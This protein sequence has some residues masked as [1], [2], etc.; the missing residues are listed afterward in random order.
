DIIR[1][2]YARMDAGRANVFDLFAD[3]FEFYFPKFG[4]GKGRAELEACTSRLGT[5]VRN[6]VH[7]PE[8]FF[9]VEGQ[10][11]A[12]VEGTS[13]GETA[14]GEHWVGGQTATGRFCSVFEF[15]DGLISSLHTYLDPDY[16]SAD[17]VRFFW[18]KEGR[19][20]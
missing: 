19:R 7:K 13:T 15:R 8:S 11:G 14:T 17:A 4:F 6:I 20:W 5:T 1:E 9:I 16:G 12:A 10:N 2:F 3:D 18:G